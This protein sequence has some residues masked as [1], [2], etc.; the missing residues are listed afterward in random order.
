MKWDT[1]LYDNNHGFVSKYGE[2]VVELLNPQKGER[3]LDLGCGT[4]DL[5]EL[6]YQKGA[7]VVGMDGSADM[8]KTA[9]EKYP[10]IHFDIGS[11]SSF[12][13]GQPFDAIFSNATLHWVLEHEQAIKCI[14]DALR[15][16]GR[17]VAEFGG[18]GNVGNIIDALKYSLNKRGLSQIANRP[19]WYF[20]SLSGYT[21]LLER[22]GFRVVLATHFDRPTLLKDD[23]GISNWLQMFG[24]TYF[25][26]MDKQLVEEMIHEVEERTRPTNFSDG[27]WYAD[28]VR[29]RVV[30]IKQ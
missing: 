21:T 5:A 30:A 24:K 8:V 16:N 13:Y 3:I 1:N 6:I 11:A 4:G 9:R 22:Y 27:N 17:L 29:L 20:P 14:H 19:V 25:E 15:P 28:Y 26:G 2:G 12:T 18:K 23:E 7:E 10:H